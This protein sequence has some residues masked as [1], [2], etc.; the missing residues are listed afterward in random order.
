MQLVGYECRMWM[1][2]DLIPS[3]NWLVN[4]LVPVWPGMGPENSQA[5]CSL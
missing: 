2:L 4:N 3:H 5:A 1:P